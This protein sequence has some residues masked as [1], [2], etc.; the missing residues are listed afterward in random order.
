MNILRRGMDLD[1]RCP[2]CWWLNEDGGHCF[3]KCKFAKKCWRD[4]NLE[5]L[6]LSLI[7]LNSAKH[8]AIKILSLEKD[9]K[10]LVID[11]L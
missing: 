11:F 6:R 9:K 7:E 2:V 5:Q 8:V 1:T 3:V 10:L 4:L